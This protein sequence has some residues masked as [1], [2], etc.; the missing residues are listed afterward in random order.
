MCSLHR[1]RSFHSTTT[2]IRILLMLKPVG[3][4][5]R[6]ASE[7]HG[8]RRGLYFSLLF[9]ITLLEISWVGYSR[10]QGMENSSVLWAQHRIIE[11]CELEGILKHHPV[12][13]PSS[14]W[15]HLQLDPGAQSNSSLTSSVSK[16]AS[17]TSAKLPSFY[18]RIPSMWEGPRFSVLLFYWEENNFHCGRVQKCSLTPVPSS[19]W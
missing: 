13:F 15:G 16:D 8:W 14:E 1:I 2:S 6:K 7:R 18:P 5:S 12:Y 10:R 19:C 11:S 9:V 3:R 4:W 17:S